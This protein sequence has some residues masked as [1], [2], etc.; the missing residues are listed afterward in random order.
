[1]PPRRL[2]EEGAAPK[3][4]S[5]EDNLKARLLGIMVNKYAYG[6]F[7]QVID[8]EEQ[9]ENP[10]KYVG[11]F[12]VMDEG[13]GLYFM[14][15]RYYDPEVGRFISKDP[16]GLAGGINMYA[17]VDSVGKPPLDTNLYSYTSNNP[18]NYVDPLGLWRLS[19][20][21]SL[22][23]FDFSSVFYDSEHGGWGPSYV[24]EPDVGVSTTLIGGGIKFSW[25]E[26]DERCAL[27]HPDSDETFAAI[28]VSKY[29]GYE[30]S[31]DGAIQS[32]NLGLGVGTPISFSTSI[33]NFA[34]FLKDKL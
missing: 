27:Y 24:R 9:V 20:G 7:G 1:M 10:F 3:K 30:R 12:G 5:E 19:I 26:S 6:V 15:A 28:G 16:I 25:G 8:K 22:M 4:N 14:R 21:G 32:F 29:L 34:K 31:L 17:Y 2:E 33:R 13:N 11:A 23:G 18:V